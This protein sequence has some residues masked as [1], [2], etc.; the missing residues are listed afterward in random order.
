MDILNSYGFHEQSTYL[1]M[2][3]QISYDIGHLRVDIKDAIDKQTMVQ[4]EEAEKTRETH[5]TLMGRL[6]DAIKYVFTGKNN[7]GTDES[8]FDMI[9]RENNETQDS[10]ENSQKTT[11]ER[12]QGIISALTQI[13]NDIDENT[14]GDREN[15]A[16]IQKAI[17]NLKLIVN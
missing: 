2:G 9:M 4:S 1:S 10:I 12:L 14:N 16:A 8:F 15:A 17:S 7:L 5:T 13:S 11:S 6:I 3:H